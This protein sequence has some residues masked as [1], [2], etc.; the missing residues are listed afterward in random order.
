VLEGGNGKRTR[1]NAERVLKG[2]VEEDGNPL[3]CVFGFGVI[4][5]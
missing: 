5:A 4:V 3:D 1:R 2:K